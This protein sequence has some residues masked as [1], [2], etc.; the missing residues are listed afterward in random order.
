[1]KLPLTDK[2]LWNLYQFL[3][4]T[5]R[6]YDLIARRTIKDVVYPEFFKLKRELGRKSERK[7]FAKLIY[8]LKQRGLIKISNLNNK[9]GVILTSRGAERALK[10]KYKMTKRRMRKDGKWQMVIFDIPERKRYL[11]DL[12]REH[13]RIFGYKLLQKSIWVSPYDTYKETEEVLR[14]YG[15][16]PYVKL[17]LIEEI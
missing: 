1:M 10:I 11:R 9:K 6:A 17:F 2:V 14:R 3:E 4:N 8:S 7:K 15:L 12:L 16:D 5:D 13:L